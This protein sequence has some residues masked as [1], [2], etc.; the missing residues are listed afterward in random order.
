MKVEIFRYDFNLENNR[1]RERYDMSV[2]Y[3]GYIEM[4]KYDR[5]MAWKTCFDYGLYCHR[6]GFNYYV[7]HDFKPVYRFDKQ[8]ENV[9][10][11][12]SYTCGSDIAFHPS[13]TD[14]YDIALPVG[15]K[16][17]NSLHDAFYHFNKLPCVTMYYDWL[18]HREN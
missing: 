3:I 13:G 11:N 10:A 7:E 8:F 1:T 17:V 14:I 9:H 12:F 2:D 15:W 18:H 6:T 5:A 4:K 16:R